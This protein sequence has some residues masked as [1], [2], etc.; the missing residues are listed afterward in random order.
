[1]ISQSMRENYPEVDWKLYDQQ[2]N[3]PSQN[4]TQPQS[5]INNNESD[6]KNIWFENGKD[7]SKESLI[8]HFISGG[9]QSAQ[10]IGK[11][12]PNP[13]SMDEVYKMAGKEPPKKISEMNVNK[14]M[15]LGEPKP[16][17]SQYWA[18]VAGEFALPVPPIFKAAKPVGKVIEKGM[19]YLKPEKAAEELRSTLGK[20]TSKEVIEEVG[21]RT[22]L[23]K[24]SALSESLIP[25]KE[26][27]DEYGN[28][29]FFKP[30]LKYAESNIYNKPDS[31]YL[32]NRFVEEPYSSNGKLQS[33]HETYKDDPKLNTYDPLQSA[34]KKELRKQQKSASAGSDIASQKVNQLTENIKN[35]DSDAKKFLETLPDKYKNLDL[36]WRTKYATGVPKYEE[37]GP[38][39]RK[40]SSGDWQELSPQKVINSF[41]YDNKKTKEVLKDLGPSA[42][43]NI[44]YLAL[45]KV[46]PNDAE[47][48]AKAILDLKRTKGFDKFI[49]P[50]IEEAAIKLQKQ[51]RYSSGIKNALKATGGAAMGGMIGGPLGAVAGAALPFGKEAFQI[52]LKKYKK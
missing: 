51:A 31:S 7:A 35:L 18:E 6:N 25:K 41:V 40:L 10:G 36:D 3:I 4:Q 28:N 34:L 5:E 19:E 24:Q 49:T 9:L 33:L 46:Q 22:Q 32:N 15:G 47:G 20:G 27:F 52:A 44:L 42:G 26:L 1:M 12:L 50:E 17:T 16:D 29:K 14:M 39:I 38:T 43:K 8:S 13:F 30:E 48:L 37:A 45:Q 21:K 23:G 11:L 2:N